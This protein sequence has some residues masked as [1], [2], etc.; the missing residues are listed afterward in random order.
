MTVKTALLLLLALAPVAVAS[1]PPGK[2]HGNNF[3]VNC[4]FSH[5]ADDDPIMYPRQPGRSHPHTFFGSLT[6]DE[7]SLLMYKH[8]DHHLTQF[9]A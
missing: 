4:R 2:L 8:L 5:T 9:S 6:A 3:Y 1:G 7:W